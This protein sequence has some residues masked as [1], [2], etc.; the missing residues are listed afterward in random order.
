MCV[1][2]GREFRGKIGEATRAAHKHARRDHPEEEFEYAAIVEPLTD[3]AEKRMRGTPTSDELIRQSEINRGR[4][5]I[6]LWELEEA[7]R[8]RRL[9]RG[10]QG[11]EMG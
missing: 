8:L 1:I 7:Q 5:L 9:A 2:C 10:E 11:E 4:P 3:E 6:R